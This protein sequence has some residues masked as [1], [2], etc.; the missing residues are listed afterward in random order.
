MRQWLHGSISTT[1]AGQT[2]YVFKMLFLYIPLDVLPGSPRLKLILLTLAINLATFIL[3]SIVLRSVLR[4]YRVQTGVAF[5]AALLWLSVIAGS[6]FWIGFAN[7]RNLEVVGGV[8]LLLLGLRWLRH[9]SSWLGVGIVSFGAILFFEDPLQVYM[10]ALPLAVYAVVLLAAKKEHARQVAMLHG[11]LALAYLISRLLFAIAAHWLHM[12]FHATGNV[13]APHISAPWVTHSL[14]GTVKAS[15]SLLLGAS[16]VGRLREAVNAGL[17]LLGLSSAVYA[18][19]HRYIP[20]RLLLLVSSI[21]VINMVVFVAS[22]Q[23]E[24]GTSASRY[25]IMIAPAL[26]LL[27]STLRLPATTRKPVAALLVM[28]LVLNIV[29]LSGALI[30]HW[31]TSFPQDAHLG[32]THHYLEQN[33]QTNTYASV[34]TAM[35]VQYLYALPASK[36]LPVGCLNG[37]LVRTYFSMDREFAATMS[38]PAAPTAI[39]LDGNT[40]TNAPNDCTV[41]S[42]SQQFGQPKQIEHTDDGSIVLRYRQ[43]VVQLA[44]K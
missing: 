40:I 19:S 18:V 5:Y 42:I 25:L 36:I 16:D 37:R 43:S 32:S 2:A 22:G 4:E 26:V 20:R 27:C 3:L 12:S 7:S 13:S 28:A 33:P 34:D 11:L 24:Q 1:Q 10:T 17:L 41:S 30:T 44:T 15:V 35:S 8:L 21:C 39:I 23:A 6:V 31:D 29:A 14:I 38:E 9:P